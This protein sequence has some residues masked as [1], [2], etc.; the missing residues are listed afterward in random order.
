[1]TGNCGSTCT[2]AGL[3]PRGR[4]FCSC[5]ACAHVFERGASS[6]VVREQELLAHA[7]DLCRSPLS[8]SLA[9]IEP[10]KSTVCPSGRRVPPLL[11]S[12]APTALV[13]T[14]YTPRVRHFIWGNIYT[15]LRLPQPRA[16]IPPCAHRKVRPTDG[17][18]PSLRALDRTRTHML[19]S[20]RGQPRYI[21]SLVYI[22]AAPSPLTAQSG[23]SS[24]GSRLS[25]AR[26]SW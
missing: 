24:T 12:S 18:A 6:V 3:S 25:A 5:R 21:P 13:Y 2:P 9:R 16:P 23:R 7:R 11:P 8:S 17:A 4:P 1:M 22:Q 26:V 14:Q 10:A 19:Y 20:F 15:L